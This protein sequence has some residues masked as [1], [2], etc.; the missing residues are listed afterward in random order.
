MSGITTFNDNVNLLDNDKLQIGTSQDLSIYHDGSHSYIDDTG[1][2]NL[3]A[4]SNNFRISN[5]DESKI[6]ATFQAAAGV[7]LFMIILHD[8]PQLVMESLSMVIY[9]IKM[10]WFT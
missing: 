8:C 10:H 3:K 4:R 2:G 9:F 5:A 1:T 6:S 7:E